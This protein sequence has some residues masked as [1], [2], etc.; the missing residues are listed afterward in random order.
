MTTPRL[1]LFDLD[2]TL[3]DTAGAGRQALE[4]A[5]GAVHGIDSIAAFAGKVRFAGMTDSGI[6]RAL[7]GAAGIDPAVFAATTEALHERYL[8]ELSAEMA[9]PEPRRRVMPGIEP[10]L[11]ELSSRNDARVGLLTGNLER[12]A[13]IKLEPFGLNPFFPGGGFGSD[14]AERREVARAA[15]RKMCRLTGVEFPPERVVVVGDTE[16]DVDCARANGFVAV[17]VDAGWIP[18]DVLASA[19]PDA[20]FDDLSDLPAVLRAFGLEPIGE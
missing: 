15:W 5:F 10:L 16:K 3:V 19:K 1:I 2:G 12:G 9:R 6:F 4:R 17:A 7:A 18:R 20:L 14:H 13:R 11:R 8:T